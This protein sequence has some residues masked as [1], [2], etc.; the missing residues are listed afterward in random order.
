MR[1][2]ILIVAGVS[3]RFLVGE[4]VFQ[5]MILIDQESGEEVA[6][7][8]VPGQYERLREFFEVDDVD[9]G[10]EKG[11]ELGASSEEIAETHR[12]VSAQ[13]PLL[14]AAVLSAAASTGESGDALSRDE[15]ADLSSY[16]PT[17]I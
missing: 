15:E 13:G 8:L 7:P 6:F 14:P 2:R 3:E 1:N 4:G 16:T 12:Q 5:E 10:Q 17:H 9:L 11:K